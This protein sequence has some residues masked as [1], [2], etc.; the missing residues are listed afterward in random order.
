M[1]D[2]DTTGAA[3]FVEKFSP[4]TRPFGPQPQGAALVPLH[5]ADGIPVSGNSHR[6]VIAQIVRDAA[7]GAAGVGHEPQLRETE[8]A[9]GRGN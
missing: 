8:G 5:R 1:S 6:Q 7:Y 3:E 9:V 2:S 4:P